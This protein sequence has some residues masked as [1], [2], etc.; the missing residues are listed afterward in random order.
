MPLNPS[1][2][3]SKE[4]HECWFI[5]CWLMNNSSLRGFMEK[6]FPRWSLCF[7][8]LTRISQAGLFSS[9][10]VINSIS[11]WIQHKLT[12]TYRTFHSYI[13]ISSVHQPEAP[14]SLLHFLFT[15]SRR[16]SNN[17]D[18]LW[19][20]TPKQRVVRCT[21][22]KEHDSMSVLSGSVDKRLAIIPPVSE[23]P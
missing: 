14:Y 6:H 4:I 10:C 16:R 1:H 20:Q 17:L 19:H 9:C 15:T 23:P 11:N 7:L 3:T 8:A 2:W 13:L 22:N 21:W 18:D 12:Q 5:F